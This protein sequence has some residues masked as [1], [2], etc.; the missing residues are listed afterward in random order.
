[1]I[2]ELWIP[3]AVTRKIDGVIIF[4]L[5]IANVANIIN[6]IAK[7]CRNMESCIGMNEFVNK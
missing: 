4:L 7:A 5:R 2:A 6:A 1:M 3:E